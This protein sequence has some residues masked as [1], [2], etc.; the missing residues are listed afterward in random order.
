MEYLL[1]KEMSRKEF[2]ATVAFGLATVAGL[3]VLLQLLGKQ[4]PWKPS[5]SGY[6]SSSY[7]GS[8]SLSKE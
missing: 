7:G 8:K 4:N 5:Q 2:L 3:S 6:G 1:Q